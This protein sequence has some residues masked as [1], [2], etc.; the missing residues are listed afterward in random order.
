MQIGNILKRKRVDLGLTQSDLET[1]SVVTQPMISLVESGNA[2]N[3]TVGRL[4]KLVKALNCALM[5]L[6]PEEDNK[7]NA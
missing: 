6:L 5:D 2:D 4:R 1:R 7:K 3:V